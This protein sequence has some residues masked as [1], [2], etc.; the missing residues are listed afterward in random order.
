MATRRAT[1]DDSAGS[2]GPT[3][4]GRGGAVQGGR[5][6][7]IIAG[8]KLC[9][10]EKGYADT[11]LTDLAKA[12]GLSVSHLLYYFPNKEAVLLEL[13]DEIC[14]GV[15]SQIIAHREDTPE[16]RIHMLVDNFF[17]ARV[18]EA[19]EI[20]ISL[21]MTT[22]AMHRPELRAKM[23]AYN[24]EIVAS[25]ED[26]FAQTPR[27]PGLTAL[28]AAEIAG[29]LWMGLFNSMEFD[30]SLDEKVARRLFRRTLLSLANFAAG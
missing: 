5:R 17:I 8:L 1:A 24:R 11:N 19:G 6:T 7:A 2:S 20:G 16:E 13:A 27:V 14:A 9:M 22:L 3:G 18:I 25:L 29:A 15:L 4:E 26:L 21:E 10:K 28:E 30:D 12:S 23:A